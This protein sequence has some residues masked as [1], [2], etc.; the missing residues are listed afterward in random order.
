[1]ARVIVLTVTVAALVL[2]LNGFA[3]SVDEPNKGNAAGPAVPVSESP[4]AIAK[5]RARV[6]S[7]TMV[8]FYMRDGNTVSGKLISDD[9]TQLIVEQPFE[10][11]IVTRTYSKREVDTRTVRT[12]PMPEW[13]YYSKLAEYFAARTWD[14]V[15][16]PDDF[17]EAIRCY[18]KA[19]QSLQA[20]GADNERIA[21]ID[22]A[23]KK[24]Q[25]D[26]VVWTREVE[27]RAKLKKLEY[28]AEAENRLKKLERTIAESNAKLNESI[29]YLDKT[30]EDLKKDYQNVDK[31]VGDLNKDMVKQINNLQVQIT[32]DTVLIRDLYLRLDVCCR[33]K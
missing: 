2:L 15:D 13:Q 27:S 17:I 7:V 10:S 11:T 1:M 24:I 20:G 5:P 29:K 6:D 23:I 25:D 18:E 14:F 21:E 33:S 9:S 3:S 12:K 22:K 4:I 30:A 16:D 28:D 32:D 19:K 8:D 31:T 26:R